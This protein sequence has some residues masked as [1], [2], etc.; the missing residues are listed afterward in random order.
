MFRC[1]E[2]GATF[3]D[4]PHLEEHYIEEVDRWYRENTYASVKS[5]HE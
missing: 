3:A 1:E 5:Q 4:W 2:C